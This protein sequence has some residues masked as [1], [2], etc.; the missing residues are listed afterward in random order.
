MKIELARERELERI[1]RLDRHIAREELERKIAAEQVYVISS[2]EIFCGWM[3]FSLFW[4]NTPFLN[5]LFLLEEFRGQG[6]GRTAV[7][8]WEQQMSGKGFDRVLTS[9]LSSEQAQHFYRRLGYV[10][11]GCL[12]L[13]GEPAELLLLK[14]LHKKA[15]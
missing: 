3:R 14:E 6:M 2:H 15:E 10:D 11:A 8:F 7:E 9:T 4:D 5:M 1:A 12:L 13:P